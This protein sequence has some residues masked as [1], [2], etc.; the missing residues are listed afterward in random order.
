MISGSNLKGILRHYQ[1]IGIL[2]DQG[3]IDED[4]IFPLIGPGIETS[5]AAINATVDYYQIFYSVLQGARLD[6]DGRSTERLSS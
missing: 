6:H 1:Q 4:F 2:L 5:T 3:L